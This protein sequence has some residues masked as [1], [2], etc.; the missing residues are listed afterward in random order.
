M[1]DYL[2]FISIFLKEF[3]VTF[4]FPINVIFWIGSFFMLSQML[5][6]LNIHDCLK[7]LT[8]FKSFQ[9]DGI[10][11]RSKEKSLRLAS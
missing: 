6:I 3:L 9:R 4:S 1:A 5:C 11:R 10:E 7:S 8:V 2:L